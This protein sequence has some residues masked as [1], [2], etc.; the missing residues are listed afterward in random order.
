MKQNTTLVT[1]GTGFVGSYLIPK[2]SQMILTTRNVERA[3]QKITAP[4]SQFLAFDGDLSI[5]PTTRIDSVVNLMGESVAEGRW[6]AAKKARIRSSRI[7]A[8][9]KLVDQILQLEQKPKVLV[10]ASAVGIYGDPCLLYTS[11]SPRDRTRSR[12]PSSA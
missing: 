10:S 5:D 11:P 9:G 7:D 2:L 6:T 4:N 1:G 8:T 12:M 3:K